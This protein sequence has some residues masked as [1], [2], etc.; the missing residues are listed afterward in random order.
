M[1]AKFGGVVLVV[2][3]EV[4]GSESVRGYVRIVCMWCLCWWR[5]PE[6]RFEGKEEES[7]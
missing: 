7:W 6:D 2:G 1:C 4:R 3:D 5:C